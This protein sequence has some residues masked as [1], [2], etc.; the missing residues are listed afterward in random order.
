MLQPGNRNW[1]LIY[2]NWTAHLQKMLTIV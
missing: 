2:P 1:Q